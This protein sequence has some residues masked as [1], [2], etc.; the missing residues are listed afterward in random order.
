[1]PLV[2]VVPPMAQEEAAAAQSTMKTMTMTFMDK[3]ALSNSGGD[4]TCTNS[5]PI[6]HF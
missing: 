1:M 6:P 2:A 3:C 4:H 5:H